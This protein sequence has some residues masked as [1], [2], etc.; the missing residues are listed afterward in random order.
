MINGSGKMVYANKDEY[1]GNWLN[2]KRDGVGKYTYTDDG[3]VY[4]GEWKHDKQHGKGVL[5]WP[6][7]AIYD[8]TVLQF[9]LICFQ[10]VVT[11]NS[12]LH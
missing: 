6:N 5:T 11:I 7:G 2:G 8:G 1:Y 4:D 10:Q 3:R 9:F 12:F